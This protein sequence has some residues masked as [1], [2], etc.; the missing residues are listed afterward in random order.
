[1]PA[2]VRVS[3]RARNNWLLDAAL[4]VA[5][6]SALLTGVYFLYL[7]TGGYAGGRNPM[8]GVTILFERHT[9]E[10]LHTW[11]GV[12]MIVVAAVHLLLHWSWVR[13]MAGRVRD[14][15]LRRGAPFRRDAA[16]KVALDLVL[17]VSFVLCAISG[18]YFLLVPSGAPLIFSDVVWD[19]IHTWTGVMLGLGAVLHLA[20]NWRWVT[21]VTAR[22]ARSLLPEPAPKTV[23]L[24]D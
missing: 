11:T 12:A 8:Y 17:A 20:L 24:E 16:Y 3:T 6:L 22:L 7:P 4:F 18:L 2:R 5:G 15:L 19:V 1:M 13:T 21:N 9:W 10:D 14:A 23:S